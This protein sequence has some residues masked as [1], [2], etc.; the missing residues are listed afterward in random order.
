MS[1]RAM[2][3]I[4][5]S[6][7]PACA[8]SVVRHQ[9][10]AING[11]RAD[12]GRDARTAVSAQV[13]QVIDSP[14]RALDAGARRFAESGFG[15]DFSRVRVHADDDAAASAKSLHALAY[16]VGD[17]IVFARGAYLPHSAPGRHLIA[18]ELAHVIQQAGAPTGPSLAIGVAASR[19]E[20]EADRAADAVTH[21]RAATGPLSHGCRAIQRQIEMRD[22]GRGEQSGFARLPELVQRLNGMSRALTYTM[23]G[24]RLAYSQ[25][26]GSTPSDF[27]RQMMEFIDQAAVIP[28]RLTNRHGLLGDRTSG[29]HDRVDVDE[30]ESAY[31]DIDDLL[32]S[33]DLAL[34]LMLVHFLRERSATPN[35][36][37]RIGSPSMDSR[38]EF[39]RVHGQG[40]Q[41][42]V[43]LLRDFFGQPLIR[44]ARDVPA[45]ESA[46]LWR[47][48]VNGRNQDRIQ[49]RDH[50]GR[51]AEQGVEAL[52]VEVHTHDGRVL[53]AE[54]YRA[55]LA[56][57]TGIHPAPVAPVP[58]PPAS[59]A[60]APAKTVP[61]PVPA[62]APAA[63]TPAASSTAAAS[64]SAAAANAGSNQWSLSPGLGVVGH[65]YLSPRRPGDPTGEVLLRL[66]A[67][68]TRQFHR[69]N[70]KGLE[71]QFPVQL[72]VSK[73]T[74]V[75]SLAGG[76]QLSYVIPFGNNYL[77][78]SAFVQ[79][80]GGA[81]FGS[82]ANAQ[83]APAVGTQLTFQPLTWLQISA[84]ATGGATVQSGGAPA[85]FDYGGTFNIT[86]VH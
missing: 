45:N 15:H 40:L 5:A 69:E 63:T 16:A 65:V 47:V 50:P 20:A 49:L 78:W 83:F 61:A 52:F 82:P 44:L 21:G 10:N 54:Q 11:P 19:H 85:T 79:A 37:R 84:Q 23:A 38:A 66:V 59:A 71:L 25:P 35:Y 57:A 53:D 29:F 31:V 58:S 56:A 36:A 80:L 7:I 39:D 12:R 14:G 34:Q 33:S 51:G 86:L 13:R 28:L 42:E 62:P 3:S 1:E 18:H 4:T 26:A 46:V 43:Q 68:Y 30:W 81:A 60:P 27:D 17:H 73:T 72:Q 9:R 41:R 74:G 70:R 48:Y 22:V 55:E 32:A 6:G 2:K 76:G 24:N 77:Q 67:A 8:A 64:A 75:V